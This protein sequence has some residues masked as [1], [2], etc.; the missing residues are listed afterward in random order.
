[1]NSSSTLSAAC[2]IALGLTAAASTAHAAGW[3]DE[4]NTPAVLVYEHA[5]GAGRSL[6]VTANIA[7]L[8]SVGF[9]DEISSIEVLRGQW[10]F[11]EH[12]DYKG[13]CITLG[14]GRHSIE[15][16]FNDVISSI[17][18]ADSSSNSG[19]STSTPSGSL[20]AYEHIDGGGRSITVTSAVTDLARQGFND[21]IS[22]LDIRQ[23]T[24]QFC[25]DA[26]FG[27]RCITL[28]PGRHNVDAVMNDQISSMR[29]VN[30]AS[31][32]GQVQD[33]SAAVTLFQHAAF[34][35]NSVAINGAT[36]DL[37]SLNFNDEASSIVVRIGRWEFCTDANFAG[38]CMLLG[39]GRH[40]VPAQFNDKISSVRP[41]DADGDRRPTSGTG[42][43]G[44][45]NSRKET[46]DIKF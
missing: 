9:N 18:M 43:S 35:G 37:G 45:S 23:G 2:W 10:L 1:M 34:G 3:A 24:W 31:G 8:D 38:R 20:A 12:A 14:P 17:R 26:E 41:L 28:G 42:N 4:R 30:A 6:N 39:A 15:A 32:Y 7:N 19:W 27:G 25:S 44:S 5:G 16:H 13:K 36:A 40:A 11:C 22:S 29:P 33:S 21:S 46:Y